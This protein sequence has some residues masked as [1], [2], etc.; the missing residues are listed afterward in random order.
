[1]VVRR[2]TPV[3]LPPTSRRYRPV[4][5]Y[6]FRR[7]AA[8]WGQALHG[9]RGRAGPCVGSLHTRASLNGS[10][11]LGQGL[12]YRD[13]VGLS[14]GEEIIEGPSGWMSGL[15]HMCMRRLAGELARHTRWF[16]FAEE[17]PQ[18]G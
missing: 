14:L 3:H 4:I 2:M 5:S 6:I 1:M 12:H 15:K 11:H 17:L 18:F 16:N 8:G 10:I 7:R 9:R 13:T